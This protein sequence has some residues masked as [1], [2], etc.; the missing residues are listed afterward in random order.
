MANTPVFLP[1]ESHGLKSL[2]ATVHGV[3]EL[4]MIEQLTL[5]LS[6]WIKPETLA[7]R[8]ARARGWTLFFPGSLLPVKNAF[9][10]K[11]E[12]TNAGTEFIIRDKVQQVEERT[13]K[14]LIK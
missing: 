7:T 11:A 12:T 5:S 8:P 9:I 13:E 14:Q 1:G 4:N 2:W 3:A 10:T 6:A